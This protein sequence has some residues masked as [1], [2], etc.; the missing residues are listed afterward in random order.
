M[1]NSILNDLLKEY[2][3]VRINNIHE[4]EARKKKIYLSNP[5]LQEID[6]K[7]SKLS[8]ESAKSI[9]NNNSKSA[10]NN[11]KKEIKNLKLEKENILK[12]LNLSLDDLKPKYNCSICKDT[13]YVFENGKTIMCNCLKQ[14]IYNIEYN[15]KNGNIIKSQ[16]F[17]NFNIDLFSNEKNEKKY[18]TSISPRENIIDIKNTAISFIENFDDENTRNLI[19]TGGTGLR[20]NIFIKLYN[21]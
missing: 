21:K 14:K 20:K 11:F 19:F 12:K 15:E 6:D 18:N 1:N 2:E 4:L 10:L 9:L 16:N 7:I 5:K 3:K 17:N 8:I 13:G